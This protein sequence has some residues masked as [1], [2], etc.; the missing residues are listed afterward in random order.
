MLLLIMRHGE[1]GWHSLDQE[2]TLTETGRHQVAGCAAQIAAS[3]W[4]PAQIWVSPYVRARQTAAIVSEI[5]NCPVEE[6]SFIT[7]EDDPGLCLNALLENPHPRLML[8][9]HMPL[10]GSLSTLLIDGHRRGIPF[11]T[12]QTVVLDMPVVGPGCAD[13]KTQFLP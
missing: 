6:K 10:V 7:P 9:S 1:A 5:L 3:P 13:L 8:V 12:S 4:R 2:R 11:M